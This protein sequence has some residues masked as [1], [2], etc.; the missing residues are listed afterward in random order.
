MLV[1]SRL[2]RS[3]QC[4]LAAKRA[5]CV[6]GC[7]Q[8]SISSWSREGIVPLYSVLVRPHVEYRVQF[9]APPFKKDVKVLECV[10]RRA[11]KLARGLE[12]MSCEERL[13]T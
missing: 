6:L 3:Q 9:W 13:R 4:A 11:T 2:N 1:G 8:H 5:N 10:Q 12:G 7:I